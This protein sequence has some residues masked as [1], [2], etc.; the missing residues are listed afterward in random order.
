MDLSCTVYNASS[1]VDTKS[2]ATRMWGYAQDFGPRAIWPPEVSENPNTFDPEGAMPNLHR[3][4]VR[5]NEKEVMEPM[6]QD[7][8]EFYSAFLARIFYNHGIVSDTLVGWILQRY[9]MSDSAKYGMLA[10]VLLIPSHYERLSHELDSIR[11]SSRTKLAGLIEIMNYECHASYLSHY[12]SHVAQ[13]APLVEAII[14]G[15]TIDFLRL[16]GERTFEV[17]CFAWCDILDSISTSGPTKFKYVSNLEYTAQ[18]STGKDSGIELMLGFPNVLVVLLARTTALRHAQLLPQE[19]GL[20]GFQLEQ[21]IRDW[22]FHLVEAKESLLRVA[23]ICAQEIWRHT[24]I[25]YV[26]HAVF[27]S[28]SSCSLVNYSVKNIIKLAATL[29]PGSTP[30][31]FLAAPYF[32]AG[33][34]AASQR[35]RYTLRSRLINCDNGGF[36]RNLASTLDELWKETDATGRLT[37]WPESDF[38]RFVL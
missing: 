14:G 9:K 5:L 38:P 26:H 12:Y 31:C 15:D 34:S 19:I 25:L 2:L 37:S 3:S 32:V 30:D 21:M 17:R 24:G 23:R 4:I 27:K 1:P 35:D 8:C 22:Q 33:S 28:D 10:T 29:K 13:A 36:V 11:L 6:F 16:R 18:S 7:M 20:Q